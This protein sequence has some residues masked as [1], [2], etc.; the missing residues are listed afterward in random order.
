MRKFS[1]LFFAL[2][3][4]PMET[5]LFAQTV[6]QNETASFNEI[7]AG[8]DERKIEHTERDLLGEY[9]VFGKSIFTGNAAPEEN[10]F[11]FVFPVT[12]CYRE[13]AFSL[14]ERISAST[15][16]ASV[17]FLGDAW[18]A[19]NASLH[20]LL[21]S[22]DNPQNAA[23]M[24]LTT[25]ENAPFAVTFFAVTSLAETVKNPFHLTGVFAEYLETNNIHFSFRDKDILLAADAFSDINEA[26]ALLSDFAASGPPPETSPDLFY[27]A[28]DVNN[29]KIIL[30]NTAV[31]KIV[32][33]A[34]AVFLFVTLVLAV[35]FN[36]KR[37][38]FIML[39]VFFL[40]T[41]ALLLNNPLHFPQD[42]DNELVAPDDISA[43]NS[44]A[45]ENGE[46][47]DEGN[48]EENG[49]GTGGASGVE[50]TRTV[51][52]DRI[53]YTIKAEYDGEPQRIA[54]FYDTEP[55][56]PPGEVYESPFPYEIDEGRVTFTLGEYPP[57]PFETEISFPRAFPGHLTVTVT[58]E[59]GAP[60]AVWTEPAEQ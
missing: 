38:F 60:P 5:G 6:R 49:D 43:P 57:N 47:N 36:K 45:Q 21:E 39:A 28:A 8:L 24:Y 2:S 12:D 26:A 34:S 19:S 27:I 33:L 20:D 22:L 31:I 44:V 30:S 25:P 18:S 17:V 16:K 14:S 53:V 59:H 42:A 29:K 40:F 56:D 9:G 11:L 51:F 13:L 10:P 4:L 15:A 54:I 58:S 23:L 52:L 41:G 46:K 35:I 50:V 7:M 3:L 55:S 37:V 48:D 32:L 1:L